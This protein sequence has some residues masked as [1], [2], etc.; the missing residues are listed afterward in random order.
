VL[1]DKLKHEQ[2]QT[3]ADLVGKPTPH[4]EEGWNKITL[5]PPDANTSKDTRAE[6]LEVRRLF[7]TMTEGQRVTFERQDREDLEQEF[8]DL[9]R[10][11]GRVVPK[12]LGKEILDLSEELATIG[13]FFK[14]RF[15]RPRP[16]ELFAAM[17]AKP[18]PEAKT[19]KSPSYP[20]NHALI[21]AFLGDWLA[22]KFPKDAVA[23]KALGKQLGALRIVG[24]THFPS[25]VEAGRRLAEKLKSFY[26]GS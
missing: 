5:A 23:L 2:V 17:K 8:I 14:E 16:N 6:L 20:S 25:D 3:D 22:A 26:R 1:T 21:G 13:L 24:G 19:A 10:R 7:K 11:L 4:F 12:D 15:Q 9:L 18:L